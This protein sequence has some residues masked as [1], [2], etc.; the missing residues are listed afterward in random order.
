MEPKTA[1]EMIYAKYYMVH[2][3]V[4]GS[5]C[6]YQESSGHDWSGLLVAE[7]TDRHAAEYICEQLNRLS[8]LEAP[9]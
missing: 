2:D 4:S 1:S 6:V 3:E 7:Y 8:A 9:E 5:F